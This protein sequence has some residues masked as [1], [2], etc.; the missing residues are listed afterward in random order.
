MNT[1]HENLYSNVI[2]MHGP[3]EITLLDGM[4]KRNPRILN[5]NV[6]SAEW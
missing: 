6:D 3:A 4:Y 2:F 1:T 5:A